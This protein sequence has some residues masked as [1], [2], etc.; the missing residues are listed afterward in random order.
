MTIESGKGQMPGFRF[1]SVET[2][3]LVAYLRQQ[4]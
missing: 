1:S 3:T 4:T 2:D